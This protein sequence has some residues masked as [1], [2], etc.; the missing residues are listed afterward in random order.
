MLYICNKHLLI[1]LISFH[2]FLIVVACYCPLLY[3]LELTFLIFNI[4]FI[5]HSCHHSY[6]HI[7]AFICWIYYPLVCALLIFFS[8]YPLPLQQ[9]T[10]S[11]LSAWIDLSVIVPSTLDVFITSSRLTL[12]VSQTVHHP[13]VYFYLV[14]LNLS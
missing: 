6:F 4:C 11:L 9:R 8:K 14:S 13:Y 7:L 2:V 12:S 10:L 1:T 3:L 5:S